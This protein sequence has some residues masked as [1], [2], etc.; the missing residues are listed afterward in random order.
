M[1][2]PLRLLTTSRVP[3]YLRGLSAL[4]ARVDVVVPRDE[5]L[6]AWWARV[7]ELPAGA[8]PVTEARAATGLQRGAYDVAVVHDVADLEVF[9][10]ERVPA[11]LVQHEPR[12][13][14]DLMG[15]GPDRWSESRRALVARTQ[16]VYPSAW[17]AESWGLDGEVIRPAID[18]RAWPLGD[19]SLPRALTVLPFAVERDAIGTGRALREVSAG[20]PMTV[21]GL[22]PGLG[23]PHDTAQ[24]SARR[25]ALASHR[26]YLNLSIAPYE[27]ALPSAM[28]EAMASGLPVVTIAHPGTPIEHGVNGFVCADAGEIRA[29]VLDLLGDATLATRLGTA[30]RA[31]VLRNF[32]PE[33]CANAWTALIDGRLRRA[34]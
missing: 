32:H 13:L 6:G 19:G 18:P 12:A 23:V 30:A 25:Q 7:A 1:R 31:S 24:W 15:D 27:P 17:V 4:D 5:G 34:A 3:G 11:V 16:V 26:L 14:A 28:L 29:R 2:R 21:L 33:A 9:A 10:S 22:N 20:L 8:R